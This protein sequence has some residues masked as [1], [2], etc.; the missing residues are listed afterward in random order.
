MCVVCV[1]VFE[2]V[3]DRAVV[4]QVYSAGSAQL[5]TAY[6]FSSLHVP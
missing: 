3:S 6:T 1:C 4:G 5:Y 2:C